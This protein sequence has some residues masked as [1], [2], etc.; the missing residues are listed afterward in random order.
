[1]TFD[2]LA[3]PVDYVLVA[4]QRTP[5][6]ATIEGAVS[7]RRIAIRMS[8]ALTGGVAVYR[9][10][11]L[12]KFQIKI[13]LYSSEDWQAWESFRSL[14]ARPPIGVRAKALDVTHP[15]LEE[16]G[17]SQA[18]VES[19][20]QPQRTDDSGEWTIVVSMIEYQKPKPALSVPEGSQETPQ[21]SPE[22]IEINALTAQNQALA[23][24]LQ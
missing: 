5:G 17:V 16:L 7:K 19:V 14:I 8:Y 13:R 3:S 11:E 2:P 12:V 20:S 23:Q 4:G 24:R 10:F 6:L 15:I 9:G 18:L 21:L 22:E 1:M